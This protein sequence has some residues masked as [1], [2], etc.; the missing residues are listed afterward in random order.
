MTSRRLIHCIVVGSLILLSTACERPA[1]RPY[2][3]V[4]PTPLA[5]QM[6]SASVILV[7]RIL[8]ASS[9]GR[10]RQY[11]VEGI[12]K[13][14]QLFRVTVAVENVLKGTVSA[15]NAAIYFFMPAGSHDGS[16]LLGMVG[17]R[18]SWNVEDLEMFF[19]NHDSGVL[20]TICDFYHHCVVPVR[21]CDHPGFRPEPGKPLAD[22]IIDLLLTRGRNCGDQQ[23]VEATSK[24]NEENFDRQYAFKKLRQLAAE[25]TPPVRDAACHWLSLW[26]Q[27]CVARRGS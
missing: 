2:D 12:S 14:A 11:E 8:G 13:Q 22:A 19:L 5:K 23:M 9:V 16:P 17:Q 1:I 26:K 21:S 27:P 20:R 24:F 10:P 4:D 7:G 3:P 25:E 18:G 6:L 15:G